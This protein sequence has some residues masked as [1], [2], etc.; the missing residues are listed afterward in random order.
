MNFL[1]LI[2]VLHAWWL[3]IFNEMAKLDTK[4]KIHY[5]FICKSDTVCWRFRCHKLN[6]TK[7]RCLHLFG[8]NFLTFYTIYFFSY[9]PIHLLAIKYN[10]KMEINF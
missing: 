9:D 4:G 3:E 10:C 2:F 1:F 8:D 5:L 7:T 6:L